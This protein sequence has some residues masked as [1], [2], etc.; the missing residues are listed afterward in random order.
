MK[1]ENRKN[2]EDLWVFGYGSLMWD[3]RLPVI[4][5]IPARLYGWHRRFSMVKTTSFGSLARPGLAAGLHPGGEATG[6]ALRI[7]A[8][9][10]QVAE[11]DLDKRERNYQRRWVTLFTQGGASLPALT[12]VAHPTNGSFDPHLPHT[13]LTHR[14]HHG[15][16]PRGTTQHYIDETAHQLSIAGYSDTDAHRLVH[17]LNLVSPLRSGK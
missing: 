12:Y 8:S 3:P 7:D 15:H 14:Y 1:L 16:G 13:H 2:G 17:R 6:L 5:T 10:R 11:A 9:N 4:E